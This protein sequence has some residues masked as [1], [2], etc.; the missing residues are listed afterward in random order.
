MTP[1]PITKRRRIHIT[2]KDRPSKDEDCDDEE[3]DYEEDIDWSQYEKC[4]GGCYEQF[5]YSG[6]NDCLKCGV[7]FCVA[8]AKTDG[9]WSC[10]CGWT[11]SACAKPGKCAECDKVCPVD[12]GYDESDEG[13]YYLEQA[14]KRVHGL[15]DEEEDDEEEDAYVDYSAYEKCRGG[16][17]RQF[18]YS[19]DHDCVSCGTIFCVACAKTEN[20]WTC[21]C[22]WTCSGCKKKAKCKICKVAYEE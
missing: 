7:I 1:V 12:T 10:E 22:G 19:G 3:E 14:A 4:R 13:P 5:L 21:E 17:Y 6:D 9:G 2:L 11:C 15:D 18:L 16:C 20:G 8:C